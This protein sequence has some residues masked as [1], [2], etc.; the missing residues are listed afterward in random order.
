MG[1]RRMG[2]MPAGAMPMVAAQ[3][4]VTH[5]V[6][7]DMVA[8]AAAVDMQMEEM[9]ALVVMAATVVGV[10]EGVM[11]AMEVMA[12][13]DLVV[14]V[15]SV[16][17]GSVAAQTRQEV[18]EVLQMHEVVMLVVAREEAR[19]LDKLVQKLAM[20][21]VVDSL[22]ACDEGQNHSLCLDFTADYIVR[23]SQTR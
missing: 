2:E 9:E 13:V 11:A 12:V 4:L 3:M 21:Q 19:L 16:W 20:F 8:M 14:Q 10:A 22:S 18:T 5:K 6:V 23:L 1:E 15:E 7:V 17:V